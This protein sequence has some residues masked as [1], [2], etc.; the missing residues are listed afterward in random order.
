MQE[1]AKPYVETDHRSRFDNA[2][3]K[4]LF[5]RF[6]MLYYSY[7]YSKGDRDYFKHE[8]VRNTISCQR[9]NEL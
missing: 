9:E 5:N 6:D 4:G 2:L 3:S 8:T 7:Q 1:N